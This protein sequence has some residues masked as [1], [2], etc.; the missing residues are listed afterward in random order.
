MCFLQSQRQ[1]IARFQTALPLLQ[2]S[3]LFHVGDAYFPC[4]IVENCV[5]V[6][7]E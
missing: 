1:L 7:Q 6:F 4:S 2:Q 3:V 5:E